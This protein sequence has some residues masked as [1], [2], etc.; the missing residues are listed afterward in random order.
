MPIKKKPTDNLSTENVSLYGIDY[1][2]TKEQIKSL[3][4]HCKEIRKPLEEY[5]DVYGHTLDNGSILAVV[6]HGDKDVCLRKTFRAG[7]VLLPEAEDVLREN[8][9]DEC[10]EMVP[11]IREDVIERLYDEGRISDELLQQLYKEKPS[12]AFSVDIKKHYNE[13]DL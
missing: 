9:L 11:T 5:L 1:A 13:E 10:I 7:K 4:G 8:G 3:E 12:Y 2:K 6:V